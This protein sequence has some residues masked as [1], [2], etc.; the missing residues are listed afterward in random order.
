MIILS[1][2]SDSGPL[3]LRCFSGW[4]VIQSKNCTPSGLVA[5]GAGEWGGWGGVG[6]QRTLILFLCFPYSPHSCLRGSLRSLEQIRRTSAWG[7][8]NSSSP[9][10]LPYPQI[11]ACLMLSSLLNLCL[12][13]IFS[14]KPSMTTRFKISIPC[15]SLPILTLC[16]P[17]PPLSCSLSFIFSYWL[18]SLFLMCLHY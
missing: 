18:D 4:D 7:L 10:P 9:A 15:F 13:L 14:T 2:K 12:N 11:P 17:N 16:I 6:G 1:W 8:G 3:C 5:V